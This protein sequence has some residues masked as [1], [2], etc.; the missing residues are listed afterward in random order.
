MHD[1]N[2][3]KTFE[4]PEVKSQ[5]MGEH[6]NLNTMKSSTWAVHSW[7]QSLQSPRRSAPLSV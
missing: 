2:D 1:P 5:Y 6:Q 7:R 4:A 3:N